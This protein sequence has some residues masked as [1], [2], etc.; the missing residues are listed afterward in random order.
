M[1]IDLRTLLG[2][3]VDVL[4]RF[5][6]DRIKL[7]QQ[8]FADV[9]CEEFFFCEGHTASST[10]SRVVNADVERPCYGTLP[11]AIW[12]FLGLQFLANSDEIVFIF[13][14][15]QFQLPMIENSQLSF[16]SGASGAITQLEIQ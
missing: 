5:C 8:S 4:S 3:Q 15:A 2:S 1:K 9:R 6:L 16:F 14:V 10:S 11:T 13:V 12:F 7:S